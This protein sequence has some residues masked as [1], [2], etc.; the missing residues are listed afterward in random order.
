MA[1]PDPWHRVA[2]RLTINEVAEL[3]AV[4]VIT[5]RRRQVA[6]LM[7]PRKRIG[8]NDYYLKSQ[9]ETW[10]KHGGADLPAKAV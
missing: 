6:G 4:S 1:I 10:L 9:I 7:P 5:I 2:D 8:K 3:A